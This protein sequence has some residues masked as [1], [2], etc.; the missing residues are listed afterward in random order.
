MPIHVV[1]HQFLGL[2]GDRSKASSDDKK[3]DSCKIDVYVCATLLFMYLTSTGKKLPRG[4]PLRCS[5]YQIWP[6]IS[7]LQCV[8][9]KTSKT[10]FILIFCKLFQG[11]R[12]YT[13]K[14]Y[15]IGGFCR[16]EKGGEIN[17]VAR[18]KEIQ[19]R[20]VVVG[21]NTS[22]HYWRSQSC[23]LSSGYMNSKQWRT[24]NETLYLLWYNKYSNMSRTQL[25]YQTQRSLL[26]IFLYPV[27]VAWQTRVCTICIQGITDQK[28][29][30][31]V[32]V[33]GGVIGLLMRNGKKGRVEY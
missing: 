32:I 2:S 27:W 23:H 17:G 5:K 29:K 6:Y 14:P 18:K 4:S 31:V 11:W 7:R 13:M 20:K 21:L 10:F 25:K 33:V 28:T 12:S 16:R 22:L 3:R 9:S 15:F 8:L 26:Y 19:S 24:G 30:I 1:A